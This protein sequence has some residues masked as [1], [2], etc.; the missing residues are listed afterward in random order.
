MFFHGMS[1]QIFCPFKNWVVGLFTKLQEICVYSDTR[2][3]SSKG[4]ANTFS[5]S[6]PKR[7]ILSPLFLLMVS[8][9]KVVSNFYKS[10]KIFIFSDYH[11]LSKKS[12]II[13]RSW[14]FSAV[15]F[16]KFCSLFF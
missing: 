16:S 5:L 6:V 3:L 1:S 4:I 8:F 14:R 2:P 7:E 11:I 9:E 15:F 10:I 13:L 12:L